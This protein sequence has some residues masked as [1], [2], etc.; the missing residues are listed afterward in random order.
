MRTGRKIT[1]DS[2]LTLDD[3]LEA[4]ERHGNLVKDM[5]SSIWAPTNE[6]TYVRDEIHSLQIK[7][8]AKQKHDA[9]E[10]LRTITLGL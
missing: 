4:I 6:Y 2:D 5:G 1:K 9:L 8:K 7:L 10:R 3:L